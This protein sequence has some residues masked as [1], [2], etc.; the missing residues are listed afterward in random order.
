MNTD[1][2][3]KQLPI[4]GLSDRK[5]II[6]SYEE[7]TEKLLMETFELSTTKRFIYSSKWQHRTLLIL[8]LF[9]SES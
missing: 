7:R 3:S 1:W 4:L 9:H 8:T 2:T 5:V 6:L